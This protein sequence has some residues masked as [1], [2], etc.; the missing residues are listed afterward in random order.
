MDTTLIAPHARSS[1]RPLTFRTLVTGALLGIALVYVFVQ[2]VL[3]GRVEMPLPIFVAISLLLAGLIGGRPLGGRR[4]APLLGTA[5]SLIMLLG[6]AQRALT[7]LAQ[8]ESTLQFGTQL[9]LLGI[10]VTGVVAGIGATVQNYRRPAVAPGL[11]G[12][13]RRGGLLMAGLLIGAIAVAAIPQAS[14]TQ[15]DASTLAQLP[16]I[17][18][19]VFDDGEIRVRAGELTA[20]RLANPSAAAHSFDVDEL[21]L[22]V[23]MPADSESLALFRADTPGVY[24]FYCA[25]HYDKA[26]GRGMRGTLI[27]EP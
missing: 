9:V 1:R 11:P 15:V 22:H 4:W 14:G 5:W 2:A 8:P 16:L 20:L 21:N 24:T 6:S 25:P 12:W 7:H 17:P 26:T 3:L 18:L 10:L 13:A 27:V 19:S 23:A